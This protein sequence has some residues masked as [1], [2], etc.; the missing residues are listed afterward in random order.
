[1]LCSPLWA[2]STNLNEENSS[3]VTD[4]FCESVSICDVVLRYW[5]IHLAL[6]FVILVVVYLV[7]NY[8]YHLYLY[9]TQKRP[10]TTLL[11]GDSV[12]D[13]IQTIIDTLLST[14]FVQVNTVKMKYP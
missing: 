12:P 5:P 10:E 1:I 4:P 8:A 7:L 13:R 6:G 2:A 11:S 9:R 14:G 3:M